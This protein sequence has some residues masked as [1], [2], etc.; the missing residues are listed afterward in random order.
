MSSGWRMPTIDDIH[1]H[2]LKLLDLRIDLI[3]IYFVCTMQ[4]RH[5]ARDM[6]LWMFL[7]QI[8]KILKLM[9][10]QALSV[11]SRIDENMD[12]DILPPI[13]QILQ[14][15][16]VVDTKRGSLEIKIFIIFIKRFSQQQQRFARI[17]F[18]D[19]IFRIAVY[20]KVLCI[21]FV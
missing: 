11:H 1:I 6:E 4:M 17:F 15:T 2:L 9:L 20:N 10:I 19:N 21:S 14:S 7:Q 12:V 18:C 3:V 16:D 5:D 8:Q 13:C